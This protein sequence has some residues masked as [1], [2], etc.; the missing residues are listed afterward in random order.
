MRPA[1]ILM[2]LVLTTVVTTNL[3]SASAVTVQ[4]SLSELATAADAVLVARV[5]ATT[6]R[7]ADPAAGPAAG[8]VTDVT[9]TVE[10]SLKGSRPASVRVTVEGGEADGLVTVASESP[11]LAVGERFVVFL[12][13]GDRTIGGARGALPVA[14]ESLPTEALTLEKLESLIVAR[15]APTGIWASGLAGAGAVS[16]A[17]PVIAALS[18]EAPP[19]G[20]NCIVEITGSGFGTTPGTVTFSGRAERVPAPIAS[21]TD[22]RVVCVVPVAAGSPG[23]VAASSG[24]I[25]LTTAAGVQAVA[26]NR[27][28]FAYPGLHWGGPVMPYVVDMTTVAADLRSLVRERALVGAGAWNAVS[29][30]A[31]QFSVSFSDTAL[32]AP[33]AVNGIVWS[34]AKFSDPRVLAQNEFTYSPVSGHIFA[35][36]IWMNAAQPWGT[37]GSTSAY[38]VGGVLAHELG[39]SISLLDQY[40][41]ADAGE[42][43]YYQTTPGRA[44]SISAEESVAVRWIYEPGYALPWETVS[45]AP[46]PVPAPVLAPVPT[47]LTIGA[48]ARRVRARRAFTVG[49]VLAGGGSGH[50]IVVDYRRPGRRRWQRFT[51]TGTWADP[52]AGGGSWGVRWATRVRGT[53]Y[54][55]AYHPGSASTFAS[56]S[57]TISVKIVR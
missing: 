7:L 54:F 44:P 33:G 48:S 17:G 10:R 38:D 39:H 37:A 42:L 41:T 43:M 45:A 11:R 29:P 27:V 24:Q 2:M 13:A 6:G 18:P 28:S 3:S 20:A 12:D 52:A 16:A 55:R 23:F 56:A 22:T 14:G 30:T 53:Y 26:D 4:T 46:A 35:S 8:V 47:S 57:R 21:W 19:A 34:S 31:F 36:T 40:G 25:G 50:Q 32:P 51:I 15:T 49:G 9:L 5:A 1:A